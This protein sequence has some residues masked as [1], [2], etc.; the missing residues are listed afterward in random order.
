MRLI[1]GA[2][3]ER[4]VTLINPLFRDETAKRGAIPTS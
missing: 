4:A 2:K 1:D 3:K